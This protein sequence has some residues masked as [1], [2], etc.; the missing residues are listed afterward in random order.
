MAAEP[1]GARIGGVPGDSIKGKPWCYTS[2]VAPASERVGNV[3]LCTTRTGGSGGNETALDSAARDHPQQG[4]GIE[5]R[6]VDQRSQHG[7]L[8][9]HPDCHAA[10]QVFVILAE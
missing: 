3:P 4:H 1:L 2:E 5:D 8:E 7:H 9:I 10:Q 6:R